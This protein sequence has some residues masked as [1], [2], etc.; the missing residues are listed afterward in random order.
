MKSFQRSFLTSK[1]KKPVLL[2]TLKYTWRTYTRRQP[3]IMVK[4][5]AS[6]S[7]IT[8]SLSPISLRRSPP[9]RYAKYV[10]DLLKSI[11]ALN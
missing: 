1:S 11:L 8:V 7:L 2:A 6:C 9:Y 5:T 10:I 3:R 4:T